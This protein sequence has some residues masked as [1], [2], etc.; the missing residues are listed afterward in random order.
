MRA[1]RWLLIFLGA[2]ALSTSLAGCGVSMD[3]RADDAGRIEAGTRPA[4]PAVRSTSTPAASGD[5]TVSPPPDAAELP[6][7]DGGNRTVT[8][9]EQSVLVT[10]TCAELTVSGTALVVDASS[11]EIGTLRLEGDRLRVDAGRA[12][13]VTI[14]GDDATVTAVAGIG[15]VE[16]SGDR[17]TA[18]T[19]AGIA[20]V[21]VRGHDNTVHSGGGVGAAVVQGSGNTIR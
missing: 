18:E 5:R 19:A 10:G 12:D 6:C 9:A 13:V 20:S 2:V 7:G 14:D 3:S 8:G 4:P 17:N 1:P 11:A 15:K 16:V 21:T